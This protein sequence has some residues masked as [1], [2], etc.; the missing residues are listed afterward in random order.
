MVWSYQKECLTYSVLNRGIQIRVRCRFTRWTMFTGWDNSEELLT[1]F[2]VFW[3]LSHTHFLS[4][5]GL[6]FME[7]IL[8]QLPQHVCWQFLLRI[9]SASSSFPCSGVIR[10]TSCCSEQFSALISLHTDIPPVSIL[11]VSKFLYAHCPR[12]K[13]FFFL[14]R[15]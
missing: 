9:D 15:K 1:S 6:F 11:F 10:L 2:A 5:C 13:T 12:S 4:L 14:H 7:I 3:W 8:E